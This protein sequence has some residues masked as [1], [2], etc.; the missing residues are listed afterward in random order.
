MY[1]CLR[2]KNPRPSASK[3]MR[4]PGARNL[5]EVTNSGE[6]RR[7]AIRKFLNQRILNLLNVSL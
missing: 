2:L 4:L 1:F 6:L 5:L 3:D 7:G